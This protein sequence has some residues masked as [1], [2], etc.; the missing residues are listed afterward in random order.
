MHAGWFITFVAR[1]I[2][3]PKRL[4]MSLQQQRMLREQGG[5]ANDT[6]MLP[7]PQKMQQWP[8]RSIFFLPIISPFNP[9]SLT[10]LSFMLLFVV[11][12][13]VRAT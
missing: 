12:Y 10:W 8:R 3:L 1:R 9:W 6:G 5:I 13:T 2:L 7:Q 4:W 11:T